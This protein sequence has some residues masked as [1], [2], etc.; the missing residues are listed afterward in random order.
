M[1]TLE[2]ERN[3]IQLPMRKE[4]FLQWNPEDGFLY[5]YNNGFVEQK[6]YMEPN[7]LY[8][9]RNILRKFYLTQSFKAGNEILQEVKFWTTDSQYRVADAALLNSQQLTAMAND[10]NSIPDFVIEI[11]STHDLIN[12]VE[13]KLSEYFLSGVKTVWHIYPMLKKIHIYT[14]I[15][16][17]KVA[18]EKDVFDASPAIPDL[19]LSVDELFNI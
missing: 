7:Q 14:S 5:E 13:Q 19:Q 10:Q 11:I 9:I 18:L 3:T 2:K 8:I 4:D 12:K 6:N 17:I 1:E 16:A 15:R